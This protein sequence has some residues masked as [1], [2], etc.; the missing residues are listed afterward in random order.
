MSF[1]A[2]GVCGLDGHEQ[3]PLP[4]ERDEGQL[5][6]LL[7]SGNHACDHGDQMVYFHTKNPDLR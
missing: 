1:V 3:T 7:G 6:V 5:G 2:G 4:G